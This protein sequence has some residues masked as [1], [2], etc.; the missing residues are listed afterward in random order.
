ML[1]SAAAWAGLGAAIVPPMS[2]ASAPVIAVRA[3]KVA[4]QAAVVVGAT[5]SRAGLATHTLLSP[6]QQQ[7]TL[8]RVLVPDSYDPARTYRTVYV[9]PVEAGTSTRFGDGLAVIQQAGLQ[10]RYDAVFVAPS[11]SEIP[12]YGDNPTT[13]TRQESHLLG[14]VLPFVEK[15]YAVSRNASD[16]LL[17]G[18]SKSGYGAFSLIL[19]HPNLFGRAVAWDA[20]LALGGLRSEWGMPQVYGSQANFANYQV[21]RL[22]GRQAALLARGP[23]RLILAGSNMFGADHALVD[24]QLRR[25][26]VPHVFVN[27][28]RFGHAWGT[29]WLPGAVQSLL[30]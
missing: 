25:L 14:V 18:F 6:F 11:F 9:L 22:I 8:V 15:T 13:M 1:S 27:G 24:R 4:A 2:D 21:T 5:S 7:P 12:W 16:R 20:P 30:A 19:R 29:G 3:P 10:N 23:C 28:P 17:A 26:G